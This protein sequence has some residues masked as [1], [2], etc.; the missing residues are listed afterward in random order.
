MELMNTENHLSGKL[1]IFTRKINAQYFYTFECKN[2]KAAQ[3][4][5]LLDPD[6]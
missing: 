5:S 6:E 2:K 1:T 3:L 4:D